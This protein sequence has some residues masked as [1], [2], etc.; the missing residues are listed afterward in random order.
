MNQKTSKALRKAM[1]F[2]VGVPRKY[3]V[4]NW[5]NGTRTYKSVDSRAYY[6]NA[7]KEYL[8]GK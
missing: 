8:N 7:K 4:T 1:K 3:E 5:S 6:Q 2:K